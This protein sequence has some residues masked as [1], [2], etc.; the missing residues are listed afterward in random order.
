MKIVIKILVFAL[1]FGVGNLVGN[2]VKG[3][4]HGVELAAITSSVIAG[5]ILILAWIDYGR[6][7]R[8]NR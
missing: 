6:Y 4:N 7:S 8:A 1:M 5:M 2:A 3:D